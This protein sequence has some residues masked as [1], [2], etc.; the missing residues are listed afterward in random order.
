MMLELARIQW[1]ISCLRA[2]N[3][4]KEWKSPSGYRESVSKSRHGHHG[5]SIRYRGEMT[6]LT[7][8]SL[9]FPCIGQ[10]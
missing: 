8:A 4:E 7:T 6:Y 1:K 2:S 10:S 3:S 5:E 9:A